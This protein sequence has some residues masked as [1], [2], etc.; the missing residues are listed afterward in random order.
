MISFLYVYQHIIY[1]GVDY[2]FE[3]KEA[4]NTGI[5]DIDT[6]HKRLFEL[7]S[8]IFHLVNLKDGFDHYDDIVA[9]ID[10]LKEYTIYHFSFEEEYMKSKNF[11][12]FDNHKIL[13]DNLIDK[14]SNI[15]LKDIDN[16]QSTVLIQL[17]D[18]IATWIGNHI[19]KEDFKYKD[20]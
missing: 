20:L 1:K 14:I 5:S 17:L 12:N 19:L 8:Q 6:Q 9:I 10:D 18:F 3:W 16:K 11:D 4:Y 13:H 2:L 7:G 15:D